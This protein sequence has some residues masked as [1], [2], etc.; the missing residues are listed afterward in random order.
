MTVPEEPAQPHPR[1]EECSMKI[2][3]TVAGGYNVNPAC[4]IHLPLSFGDK[5]KARNLEVN[6]LVF[7]MPTAYN[8]ILGCPTLHMAKAREYAQ[9]ERENEEQGK[10][11][12]LHIRLSTVLTTLIFRSPGISMQRLVTLSP[13]PSPSPKEEVSG[14]VVGPLPLIDVVEPPRSPQPW[15]LKAPPPTD[16]AGLFFSVSQAS[17]SSFSFSQ[18][19]WYRVTSPCSLRHSVTALT[20]RTNASAIV[21][22][23]LVILGGSEVPEAAKSQEL[24]KS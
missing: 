23:S 18:H 22:S 11:G 19:R 7:D 5:L 1:D 16:A 9:G 21:I 13:A 8:V 4:T 20:P 24:T 10:R 6:F 3:A 15:P 2:V 17:C 14:L 12:G